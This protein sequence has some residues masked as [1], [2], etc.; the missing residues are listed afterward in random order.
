MTVR[1]GHSAGLGMLLVLL[2]VAAVADDNPWR[3]PEGR[4]PVWVGQQ[5][6]YMP[7]AGAPASQPWSRE[8][9]RSGASWG[10]GQSHSGT[11]GS[12]G[13]GVSPAPNPYSGGYPTYAGPAERPPASRSGN[14]RLAN[15]DPGPAARTVTDAPPAQAR[16]YLQPAHSSLDAM[17]ALRKDQGP[18]SDRVPPAAQPGAQY[19]P[20]SI[21]L[22]DFPPMEDEP[23]SRSRD[24]RDGRDGR[25]SWARQGPPPPSPTPPPPR[26]DAW[27]SWDGYE[28]G[29]SRTGAYGPPGGT[30]GYAGYGGHED[31]G[32]YGEYPGYGRYAGYGGY[33]AWSDPVFT[34]PSTISSPWNSHG[35]FGLAHGPAV[36][37]PFG[38]W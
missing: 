14:A 13:Y 29:G 35:A 34:G 2:P 19:E 32:S 21:L 9:W 15:L 10:G 22:G 1:R 11:V 36:P 17:G 6:W 4:G 7:S 25:G 31:Y 37:G 27:R 12:T 28:P 26:P 3:V 33:G 24:W 38:W 5:G 23:R 16:G 18:S 30:G 8:Q 20:Q